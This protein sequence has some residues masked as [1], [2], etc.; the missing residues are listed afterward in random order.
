VGC[1]GLESPAP[2]E[3]TP[4]TLLDARRGVASGEDHVCGCGV[5]GLHEK[6]SSVKYL[7]L[8]Y[9]EIS[10]L[11]YVEDTFFKNFDFLDLRSGVRSVPLRRHRAFASGS[12]SPEG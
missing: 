6:M 3:G 5:V 8:F 9:A 12:S 10:R 2:L 1:E 7:L 11:S 4:T